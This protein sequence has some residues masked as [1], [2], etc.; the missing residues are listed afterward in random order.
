MKPKFESTETG[1][2]IIDRIERHRYQLTTHEET[3]PCPA[4]TDEFQYPVDAA[5]EIREEMITLP[6]NKHV[7][8]RKKDGSMVAEAQPPD[9]TSLPKGEYTLEISASLKI[10]LKID[11]SLYIYFDSDQTHIAISDETRVIVGARSYHTRPAN[12]ITT[13]KKPTDLMKAITAF[14]SALKTTSPERSYPTLRGHPPTI[15]LGDKFELP[16]NFNIPKTGV[17]IEVPPTYTHVYPITSLSYYTGAKIVPGPTPK[18]TT[19][20]GFSYS[21]TGKDGFETVVEQV[22]KQIFFLDCIVR[23]EGMTPLPLYER[24]TVESALPFDL[25]NIYDKDI[26]KQ[27]EKYL[28]IPFQEIEKYLP[29]WRLEMQLEPTAESSEFLPFVANNLAIVR[30]QKG[31]TEPQFSS[32]VQ[33]N[34]IDSFTRSGS[35]DHTD[36]VRGKGTQSKR[37]VSDITTI[38]QSWC[39]SDSGQITSTASLSAFQN[40]IGRTPRVDPI[41]INVV[42][43]DSDMRDELETVNG[44]YGTHEELPFDVSVYYETTT[45]KLHGILSDES[46]FLHYI[47]HIDDLGFQCTDGRLDA[48]KVETV[49][50]KAFF[51]NACQSHDQGMKLVESGSIGG[52]VTFEDVVNRGATSVGSIIARLLNHGFS[53][54]SALSLARKENVVGEQYQIVGEGTTTIAQSKTGVPSVCSIEEKQDFVKL[55]IT[56]Y[57]G[58]STSKGSIVTPHIESINLYHLLPGK[59]GGIF[60]TKSQFKEFLDLQEIP[61]VSDDKIHWSDDILDE[62]Q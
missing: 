56:T 13:T 8:I 45:E 36:I 3:F 41:E 43:N 2:E 49:G 35:I 48:E 33:T 32:D 16:P 42:C 25:D 50:A 27:I 58:S 38:Q 47:G 15:R 34:A 24:Q 4:D 20:N 17:E 22:L 28:E 54:Y 6:M 44:V 21:L 19:E 30:V 39:S 14:G 9:P 55:E 29:E 18:L 62:W 40:S 12:S 26:S 52:I 60:V 23:T 59:I 51:L 7:Y 1:L 53:L 46:D 11:G 5:V 57:E 31:L 61:V 37:N 10:Y